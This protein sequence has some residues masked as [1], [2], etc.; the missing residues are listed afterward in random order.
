MTRSISWLTVAPVKGLALQRRDELQLDER[1]VAENR[2]FYVVDEDGRRFGLLR[3]GQLARVAAEYT[4]EPERLAL[5][6][7][8]GR[9]VEDAV[10]LGEGISTDFYGRVVTGQVVVGPFSDALTRFARRPLR[11]VRADRAGGG[12]DRGRGGVS[13]VSD[14]SVDEL[15][16]RSG[17]GGVDARRFRMLIGLGG[18]APHE[19][20]TWLGA[21][22][23]V[24]EARVRVVGVVGRCAITTQDPETG[25]RDFDTLRAIK[26][27]RGLSQA[28]EIP[29]GVFG[30]VVRPG[31][32]RVGD[33]V[34]PEPRASA[35]DTTGGSAVAR[36]P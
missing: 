11:L 26:G 6:F 20:D 34:E 22:V 8:D 31:R 36:E 29:F 13:L 24:G 15:A 12:V 25:L 21:D 27:Y 32:I 16:R 10:E 18:C 9:V 4:A 30:Y 5:R 28:G 19:E 35:R 23:R 33:P 7:P 14:A 17:D 1:G 2:R 3:Y